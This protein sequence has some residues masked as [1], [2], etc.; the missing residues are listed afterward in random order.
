MYQI[1]GPLCTPPPPPVKTLHK[2]AYSAKLVHISK[3]E[4]VKLKTKRIQ[5]QNHIKVKA[6]QRQKRRKSMIVLTND[7]KNQTVKF[8]CQA[9]LK[10]I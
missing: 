5:I 2:M 1:Y 4:S 6:G 9:L 7:I 8:N 3:K 10:G